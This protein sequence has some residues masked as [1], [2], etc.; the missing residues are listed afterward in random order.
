MAKIEMTS[1]D[2]AQ[3][4]IW[5]KKAPHQFAFATGGFL[6]NMAFHGRRTTPKVVNELMRIRSSRFI[7]SIIRVKK[8]STKWPIEKQQ[9]EFG[10]IRLGRFTG[11]GEH[12]DGRKTERQRVGTL[13]ARTGNWN[14]KMVQP[15]RL[16]S[17]NAIV[18]DTDYNITATGGNRT[19]VFL[20]MLDRKKEKRPFVIRKRYK[21]MTKGIYRM[22]SSGRI[23]RLQNFEPERVQPKRN[24][25]M[26]HTR[27]R[28]DSPA[29][30]RM[31]WAK[32]IQFQ[33]SRSG[34]RRR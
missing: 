25:W 33:L 21:K 2:L 7:N 27:K 19:L 12:E 11:W 1:R 28:M 18:S 9:S 32:Q 6:N 15:S 13:N 3:M 23:Q 31:I 5:Y 30:R 16:K 4:M 24:R 10:T 34:L 8:S 29:L 17:S 26:T 20:Q 14:R 22:K